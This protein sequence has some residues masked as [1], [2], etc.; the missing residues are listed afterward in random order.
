M[1]EEAAK[2]PPSLSH[3]FRSGMI[4]LG[5]LPLCGTGTGQEPGPLWTLQSTTKTL[6]HPHQQTGSHG[7]GATCYK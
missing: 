4:I 6:H 7:N 3:T 5:V 2:Y 1:G